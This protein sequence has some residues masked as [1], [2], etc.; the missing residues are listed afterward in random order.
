[1]QPVSNYPK[2]GIAGV[3]SVPDPGAENKTLPLRRQGVHRPKDLR[4][5]PFALA[6]AGE[7]RPVAEPG[8]DEDG[9]LVSSSGCGFRSWCRVLPAFPQKARNLDHEL[10]S[11]VE[12]PGFQQC[13][14][15]AQRPAKLTVGLAADA[16]MPGVRGVQAEDHA[17]GGGLA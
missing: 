9:L 17:H 3:V 2:A 4:A 7:A 13:S 8:E 15:L 6:E 16:G 1:M 10:E 14:G 11:R 12:G 5:G